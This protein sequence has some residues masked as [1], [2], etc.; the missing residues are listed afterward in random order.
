MEVRDQMRL[1]VL[2][3]GPDPRSAGPEDTCRLL[4]LCALL[5]RELQ[6][7]QLRAVDRGII[8]PLDAA[9]ARMMA[10]ATSLAPLRPNRR[11]LSMDRAGILGKRGTL[12]AGRNFRSAPP[13]QGLLLVLRLHHAV[14]F[15]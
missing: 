7:V 4:G 11:S 8:V 9:H 10:A 6:Q 2:L 5:I 1:W 15:W 14:N 12:R 3:G 13:G